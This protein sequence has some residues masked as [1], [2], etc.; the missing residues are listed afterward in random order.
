M[1]IIYTCIRKDRTN[2]ISHPFFEQCEIQREVG[3]QSELVQKVERRHL[4]ENV[5]RDKNEK[6]RGGG[7][8]G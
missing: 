6:A 7:M 8:K 1:F 2:R 4:E 5:E 3:L